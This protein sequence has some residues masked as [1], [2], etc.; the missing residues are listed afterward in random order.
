M[1][2]ARKY[3]KETE[4]SI[5][6]TDSGLGGF[7]VFSDIVTQIEKHSPWESVRLLYFNAWPAPHRGYNHYS[8][9]KKRIRIFNHA[10]LRMDLFKPDLI[11]IACNTLSVIYPHTR[12]YSTSDTIVEGIVDHGINI[13]HQHLAADPDSVAVILG[14]PTTVEAGSHEKGLIARGIQPERIFSTGCTNLAGWIERKPF[15]KKVTD[16]IH[17]FAEQTGKQLKGFPGNIYAGLCCTHFGYKEEIF[18]QAFNRFFSG[19]VTFLNPNTVMA[20]TVFKSRTSR[21]F[22]D[23]SVDIGIV[24]K[25][26]WSREQIESC[27]RMMPDMSRSARKALKSYSLDRELFQVD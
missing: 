12:F 24:S 4:H 16:M 20:D 8:S 9:E 3:D 25:A 14:T 22:T 18:N 6:V 7:S 11:L 26:E 17:L 2:T 15:S 5:I 13:L 21:K 23:P 1:N 27:F 19:K 10:L